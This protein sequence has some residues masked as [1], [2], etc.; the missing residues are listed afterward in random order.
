M[1]TITLNWTPANDATSTGQEIYRK[2]GGVTSFTKIADV[3][4]SAS[5]YSDT[6]LVDNTIYTYQIVNVCSTGATTAS[7]SA[8]ANN[9]IC[10][11]ITY[12]ITSSELDVIS[13]SVAATTNDVTISTVQV[14]NQ[15][16]DE[17]DTTTV[18]GA[19]PSSGTYDTGGAY[20]QTWTVRV[21][22]TD[23]TRTKQ[24]DESVSIGAQPGCGA[25]TSL[26][27]TAS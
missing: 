3:A 27:A 9:I 10:P 25:P 26:T 13:W 18:N 14:L 2:G 19:G 24:C 21:N 20:N 6:G 15:A 16:G 23:G 1:A 8:E 17:V 7:G 11:T 5:T 4:A 12:T 22:L